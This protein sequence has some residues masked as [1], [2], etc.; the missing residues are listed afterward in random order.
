MIKKYRNRDKPFDP[1]ETEFRHTFTVFPD[2]LNYS[3]SLFGG[4]L[5]AEMDLAASNAA[6]KLLYGSRCDGLVTA[7]VSAVDFKKPG[8]LGDIIDI[9][10]KIE[11]LGTTSIVTL[12]EVSKEDTYGNNASICSARFV[13][14]ALRNGKPYP[15]GLVTSVK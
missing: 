8:Y 9:C 3:G 4:K 13:F 6:R 10:T 14:V 5:L 7:H 2:S 15:H 11:S 12:V 1:A